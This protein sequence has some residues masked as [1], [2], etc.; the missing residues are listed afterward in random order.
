MDTSEDPSA[1][2]K[3]RRYMTV[4]NTVGV[5]RKYLS[6]KYLVGVIKT[7]T[8]EPA[9]FMFAFSSGL[10]AIIAYEMYI[11]KVCKVNLGYNDTICDNIQACLDYY[12]FLITCFYCDI[13]T[14]LMLR[15]AHRSG[16]NLSNSQACCLAQL[17]QAPA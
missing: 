7:I 14:V 12:I 8:I 13:Y 9:Y 4:K 2:T 10:W 1:W 3:F 16:Q 15:M 6:W 17:C 5:I 11:A